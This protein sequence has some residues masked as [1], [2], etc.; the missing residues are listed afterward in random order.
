M[1]ICMYVDMYMYMYIHKHM[2]MC[3]Y[4]STYIYIYIYI[5]YIYNTIY[6]ILYIYII[7]FHGASNKIEVPMD[8]EKRYFLGSR[9]GVFIGQNAFSRKKKNVDLIKTKMEFEK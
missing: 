2:H 7:L 1:Y 9:F 3:M 6:I 4:I 5:L 8:P